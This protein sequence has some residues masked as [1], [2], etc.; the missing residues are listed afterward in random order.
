MRNGMGHTVVS[1]TW[2]S[3]VTLYIWQNGAK[4]KHCKF[5]SFNGIVDTKASIVQKEPH[6]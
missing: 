2:A 3:S 6:I 5:A 1:A 4:E